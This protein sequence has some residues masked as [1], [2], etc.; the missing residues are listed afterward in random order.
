[1][2]GGLCG[3]PVGGDDKT[4]AEVARVCHGSKKRRYE[5]RFFVEY[6]EKA[7][8][9]LRALTFYPPG[10]IMCIEHKFDTAVTDGM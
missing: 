1:M 10:D 5:Y 6:G 8:F 7:L 9:A 4:D 2:S 3:V